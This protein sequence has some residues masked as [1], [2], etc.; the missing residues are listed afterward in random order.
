M[1][2]LNRSQMPHKPQ[3]SLTDLWLSISSLPISVRLILGNPTCTVLEPMGQR[4]PSSPPGLPS[5]LQSRSSL[6]Y[7]PSRCF[8]SSLGPCLERRLCSQEAG[9]CGEHSKVGD[10]RPG[11]QKVVAC[12][13]ESSPHWPSSG[14]VPFPRAGSAR[15]TR[16]SEAWKLPS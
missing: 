6:I 12:V 9:G 3:L 7:E 10:P 16:I 4:L 2:A 11:S 13:S 15:I 14:R 5:K 1:S 8:F